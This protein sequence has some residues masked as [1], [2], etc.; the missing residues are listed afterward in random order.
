MAKQKVKKRRN[1]PGL[2]E[3]LFPKK[4]LKEQ[5]AWDIAFLRMKQSI[6]AAFPDPDERLRYIVN[7][8]RGLESDSEE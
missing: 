7:L 4:V 5:I 8:I 2:R 6:E 3:R 1:R